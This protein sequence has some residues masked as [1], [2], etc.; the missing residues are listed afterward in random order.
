M[1]APLYDAERD[2]ST[3]NPPLDLAI[4]CAR[5]ALARHQGSDIHDD[6]AMLVAA[7]HLERALRQLVAALDNEA[8]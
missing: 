4:D 8:W 5:G 3:W 2:S 6:R 7:V 1:S